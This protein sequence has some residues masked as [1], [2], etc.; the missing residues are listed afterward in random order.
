LLVVLQARL[1]VRV[2][3]RVFL[4]GRSLAE[5]GALL[6]ILVGLALLRAATTWSREVAAHRAAARVRAE[7]RQAV[8]AHLVDLGP[9]YVRGERTGELTNTVVQGIE[10]LDPYL[11]EYLPQLATAALVPLLILAFVLPVDLLSAV[12]LFVTAPLI[13][14]FMIL[15]GALARRLTARQW[16]QLSRM[17]AHFLDLLQGFATLKLLGRS[18]E[19]LAAITRIS[20]EFRHTTMGVLRVAFLSALVLEMVATLSTAVV[21]VTVGLRL[22]YGHVGFAEALFVLILAPEFYLPVRALGSAFHAAMPGSEAARRLFEVLEVPRSEALAPKPTR[23]V[24]ERAPEIR[25]DAVRYAYGDR[26]ALDGVSFHLAAGER[27]ALVGPSGAGK[28]TV[29]QL[30]LRLLEPEDG[31]ITVDGVALGSLDRHAW[32]RRVAW[33]PQTASLFHGSVAENIRLARPDAS[34][35]EVVRAAELARADAFIR[36]LPAGYDTQV[37]E[38]GARLSGGEL[39]RIALARAFLKDAS[40]L[41]LDEATAHLDSRHEAEVQEAIRRLVEGRTVLVIAHRLNTVVDA[42]RIV[43]LAQGR[44]VEEGTHAWLMGHGKLYPRLVAAFAGG[45]SEPW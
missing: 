39:Q 10:A 7:L 28:S 36:R 30:L 11:R 38:R 25:F 40:V 34:P 4:G 29:G 9:A 43:L 3:D 17:S 33:V 1:L 42:D 15:I 44:V 8:I 6:V 24:P 31:R 23:T 32:A 41:V 19:Q 35:E 12:I 27:M 14:I 2:I 13:P 45:L 22:L 16:T 5:V 18:G 37:G 21:A 26:R 20:Q